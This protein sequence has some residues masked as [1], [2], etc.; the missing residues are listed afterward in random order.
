MPISSRSG[1]EP[2]KSRSEPVM[3]PAGVDL[4]RS[5]VSSDQVRQLIL[6]LHEDTSLWRL[7]LSGA[8]TRVL[9]TA[10]SALDSHVASFWRVNRKASEMYCIARHEAGT[11]RVEPSSMLR[12]DDHPGYFRS[13]L[14]S[15]V[16]AIQDCVDDARSADIVEAY[17]APNHVNA[18]MVSVLRREGSVYGVVTFEQQG[19]ERAWSAAEKELA[20]AIAELINQVLLVGELRKQNQLLGLLDSITKESGLQHSPDRL[21]RLGMKKLNELFPDVW[22]GFYRSY[23]SHATAKLVCFVGDEI[24]DTAR[25]VVEEIPI[26]DGFLKTVTE[27]GEIFVIPDCESWADSVHLPIVDIAVSVGM[28]SVISIPLQ[29]S[30]RVLGFIQLWS[31]HKIYNLEADYENY[32]AIAATFAIDYANAVKLEQLHNESHLDRL[33]GLCNRE[34]LLFDID[35]IKP[36]DISQLLLMEIKDFKQVN[37][38]LGRRS[39]D[40]I[41]AL[42]ASRL[43]EFAGRYVATMAYRLHGAEFCLLVRGDDVEEE[44][45]K[46]LHEFIGSPIEVDGLNIVLRPVIGIACTPEHGRDGAGLL[47]SADI[48][49]GWAK[50]ATGNISLYEQDKDN[51][52]PGNLELL[53]ELREAIRLDK[54][55]LYYQPQMD[56][57]TGQMSAC[58]ALLRWRHDEYGFIDPGTF[59]RIAESGDLIRTLTTWVAK[60]AISQISIFKLMG[61]NVPVTLNVSGLDIVDSGFPAQIKTMLDEYGVAPDDLRLELTEQSLMANPD[62]ALAV[63]SDLQEYG[64]KLDI[65]DFGTGYSSIVY[66]R[67]LPINSIK[68]DNSLVRDIANNERNQAIISSVIGMAHGLGTKVVAE[69]VEDAET[70]NALLSLGCDSGQGYHFVRPLSAAEFISRFDQWGA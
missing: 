30:G 10:L 3:A 21:A 19:T 43:E 5:A 50:K 51:L 37:D 34:K 60:H 45:A 40:R 25:T 42:M 59:V 20:V 17:L 23:D 68:I 64:L 22:A 11:G 48:A 52:G 39:G 33:T 47:R 70:V 8:L 67:K 41:L 44:M 36:D 6:G 63:I 61:I 4:S 49:L 16:V 1:K 32:R 65:D 58:E 18:L 69:A 53:A 28:R 29:H 15:Q 12:Q 54:I 13:V 31:R 56:L 62:Q 9:E 24:P 46:R 35:G 14:E 27:L 38:T 7:N 2:Y 57:K 55:E 26:N 66:L